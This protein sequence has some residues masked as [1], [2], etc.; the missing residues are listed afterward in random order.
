MP[1]RKREDVYDWLGESARRYGN[2]SAG[3]L[4]SLG[5]VRPLDGNWDLRFENLGWELKIAEAMD[6]LNSLGEARAINKALLKCSKLINE[7][8]R[9][10][11]RICLICSF[12]C[13][14]ANS[15]F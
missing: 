1:K 5:K 2:P 11:F 6:G 13:V 12:I 9:Y 15:L 4:D 14:A 3:G 10:L 8:M 7:S